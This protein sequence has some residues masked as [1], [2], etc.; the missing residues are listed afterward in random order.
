M[1]PMRRLLLPIAGILLALAASA[2]SQADGAASGAPAPAS[3]DPN[4]PTIVAKDLKFQQSTYQVPSGKAF[5]L[6]L[7]NRDGAPHNVVIAKDGGFGDK[8]F[9]G[10]VFSGPAAKAYSVPSL[11]PGTYYFRC[12]VHP[13]MQG[14]LVAQ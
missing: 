6:T 4:A 5:T 3:S 9:E 2:C 11:A 7:D 12:A 10:E 1:F 8:V 13:D 14:T